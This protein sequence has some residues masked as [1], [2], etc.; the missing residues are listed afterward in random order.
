M[1][2]EKKPEGEGEAE[3]KPK[4]KKKL[5]III[6]VVVL[7]AGGGGAAMMLGGSEPP[8]EGE[9]EEHVAEEEHKTYALLEMDTFIVNLSANTSFL[10]VKMV[11]EYDPE[12][13]NKAL[14]GGHGH[15]D[16]G[17][18][19]GE[20]AD[21]LAG[22]GAIGHRMP[23]ITD[24]II[25]VLSSKKAEDVL[26]PEGKEDLKQ[27]LIEAINEATGLDEGPIVNIYFKEFIIQ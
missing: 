18:G 17:A 27:Q 14:G 3:A 8:K 21:P 2:E 12:I 15:G 16:A 22:A 26:S 1:S 9:E 24:S 7:L 13:A 4:S 25:R 10:K 5:F 20:K 23:Q 11:L 6:G 19:G